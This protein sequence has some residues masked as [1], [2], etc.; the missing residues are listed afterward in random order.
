MSAVSSVDVTPVLGLLSLLADRAESAGR[1]ASLPGLAE[2]MRDLAG[3]NLEEGR[4]PDGTPHPA[5]KSGKAAS[6]ARLVALLADTLESGGEGEDLAVWSDAPLAAIFQFGAR[7][8]ARE[9]NPR[10]GQALVWPGA[11]HP[12]SRVRHPGATI[13]ARPFLGAG[14]D[15]LDALAA[16]VADFL[17]AD[18][19]S[20]VARS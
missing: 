19:S 7:I 8:P 20:T 9:I 11:A 12:V 10:H 18:S 1:S 13:P 3:R 17:D 16:S 2:V 4:G 14:P 5:R 6:P 15:D